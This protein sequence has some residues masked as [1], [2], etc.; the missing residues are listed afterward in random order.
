LQFREYL[1]L[2]LLIEFRLKRVHFQM[3]LNDS[4]I[5]KGKVFGQ[6]LLYFL[7]LF[8][9]DCALDLNP[10][11]FPFLSAFDWILDASFEVICF[12]MIFPQSMKCF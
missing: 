1:R 7:F 8:A 9:E 3:N 10:W 4:L 2:F 12:V 5:K 11:L 6:G